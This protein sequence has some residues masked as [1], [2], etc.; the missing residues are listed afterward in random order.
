[1]IDAAGM[2]TGE[3]YNADVEAGDLR[4]RVLAG[5]PYSYHW[6]ATSGNAW[7]RRVLDEI[8][9]I[10]EAAFA[11]Y[12]D[13][14]L[15]GLAPLFGPVLACESMSC[16]R[17]HASN[18]TA[19][20]RP[21]D[22]R[23]REWVARF[24]AIFTVTEHHASRLGLPF[25]RDAWLA[26]SWFHRIDRAVRVIDAN[27]PEGVPVILVD[28]DEWEVGGSMH[29]RSCLPFPERGGQYAGRPAD[30][31][32]AVAAL[33]AMTASR[34]TAVAVAWP[35]FWWLDYYGLGRFLAERF[36]PVAETPDIC[37]FL[38]RALRFGSWPTVR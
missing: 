31:R 34:N 33:E 22:E 28:D 7:Q 21:F 32:E 12:V 1:V 18:Y 25:D 26:A 17:E 27:V 37:L 15:C 6:A 4:A 5:G 3:F 16:W 11:V 23:L 24:D 14:Y 8:M 10:D 36:R 2:P 13:S 19:L 30:K 29:G 9:P 20:L 35:A 38:D